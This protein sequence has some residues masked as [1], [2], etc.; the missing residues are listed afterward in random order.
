MVDANKLALM[1]EIFNKYKTDEIKAVWTD[2]LDEVLVFTDGRNFKTNRLIIKAIVDLFNLDYAS[3]CGGARPTK[4][5]QA[6]KDKD[7][8]YVC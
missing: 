2:G 7:G 6:F 8:Y 3:L 4:Y 1:Q 5:S